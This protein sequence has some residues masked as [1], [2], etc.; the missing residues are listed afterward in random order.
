MQ[1]LNRFR[2]IQHGLLLGAFFFCFLGFQISEASDMPEASDAGVS[3][4]SI[5]APINIIDSIP[6]P[7]AG[8]RNSIRVHDDTSFAVL[9]EA[10]Y[11][12]NWSDPDSVRFL[13]SD[14]VYN[15]YERALNSS[16]VRVV[17]IES[18][19]SG[20]ELVWIVYDRSLD[21]H[22]P[23]FYPLE[24]IVQIQVD[25]KDLSG[26]SI[27]ALTYA[28]RIESDR[29]QALGFNRLPESATFTIED[30]GAFYDTGIEIIDSRFAGARIHYNGDEPL[31]PAFGPVDEIESAVNVG[32]QAVG[33][34]LNLMP[35]T[36][37]NRPVK[38]YIPF[39]DGIDTDKLDIY[40]HNGARWLP[41]C[42]ADGN[43]LAGGKG[44]MVPGSRINHA[45][46]NP[47]VVEI[48][49]YHF[50]AAQAVISGSSTTTDSIDRE[51]HGSGVTVVASCF[52]DATR[53]KGVSLKGLLG[54]LGLLGL[55]GWIAEGLKVT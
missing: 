30:S 19:A 29:E 7:D 4:I 13:I 39:P 52:I 6:Q 44:W 32:K 49:V 1:L 47:P 31:I 5:L 23:P 18:D 16:A 36:V 43:I 46:Q 15:A 42:D 14:G 10:E 24:A 11:G 50:S 8:I 51:R 25:I 3:P 20:F 45:S 48:E 41:A 21:P 2:H 53:F 33:I 35:H 55:M 34:P 22:L 26:N 9:V 17:A 40:Y 37:F 27:S 38:L 54:L 28:F 12:I